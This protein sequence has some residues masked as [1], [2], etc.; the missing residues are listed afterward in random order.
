MPLFVGEVVV[1]EIGVGEQNWYYIIPPIL[2]TSDKMVAFCL[3]N[4]KL[5]GARCQIVRLSGN[6]D[7][8]DNNNEVFLTQL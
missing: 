7:G 8:A 5:L 2:P 1:G 3:L 6:P 4:S